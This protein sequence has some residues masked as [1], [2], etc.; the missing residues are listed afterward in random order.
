MEHNEG[1]EVGERRTL[2][3]GFF[4]KD[5]GLRWK[6]GWIQDVDS[7]DEND[8]VIN[9]HIPDSEM[10]TVSRTVEEYEPVSDSWSKFSS[11]DGGRAYH[12][13]VAIR[14]K[15]FVFGGG[16]NKSEVYDSTSKKFA[17]LKTFIPR[18]N[19]LLREPSACVAIEDFVFIFDKSI[20]SV[21]LS[22]DTRCDKWSEKTYEVVESIEEF[23]RI[24]VPKLE[25]QPL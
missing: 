15:L 21:V 23:S 20:P 5:F 3:R 12:K 1:D 8:D 19:E 24:Q 25:L 7:D 16:T 10:F 11:M 17:R 22:Y 14:N 18:K 13:S 9:P 4:R 2:R 6:E